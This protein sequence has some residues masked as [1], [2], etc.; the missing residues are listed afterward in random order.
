MQTAIRCGGLQVPDSGTRELPRIVRLDDAA[1]YLGVCRPIIES[2]TDRG[3]LRT[4]P[5]RTPRQKRVLRADLERIATE[6]I[7]VT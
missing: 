2:W 4:V 7:P 3:L 6:G 5:M 1:E